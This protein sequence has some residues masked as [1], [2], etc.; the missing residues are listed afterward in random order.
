MAHDATISRRSP[1]PAVLATISLIALGVLLT[2]A[3]LILPQSIWSPTR[4]SGYTA[5]L[6]KSG[7]T[8]KPGQFSVQFMLAREDGSPIPSSSPNL[9]A[10]ELRNGRPVPLSLRMMPET[11]T[12]WHGVTADQKRQLVMYYGGLTQPVSTPLQVQLCVQE[13]EPEPWWLSWLPGR[14]SSTPKKVLLPIE[15]ANFTLPAPA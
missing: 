8:K 13:E 1:R 14:S 4:R 12:L 7:W 6:Q 3:L 11:L 15:G 10:A 9:V 5:A 2:V